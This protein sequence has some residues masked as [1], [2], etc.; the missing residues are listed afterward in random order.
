M[1]QPP[2]GLRW[3]C[4]HCKRYAARSIYVQNSRADIAGPAQELGHN[5][6]TWE[7][8]ASLTSE[9]AAEAIAAFERRRPISEELAERRPAG[10]VR[11]SGCDFP[12]LKAASVAPPCLGARV[13]RR[14]H[15]HLLLPMLVRCA[16]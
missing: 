2:A 4:H 16:P 1:S 6:A 10:P 12:D 7:P 13:H 14:P 8:A 15:D 5:E 9:E 11:P 3:Q